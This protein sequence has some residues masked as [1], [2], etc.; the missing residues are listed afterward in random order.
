MYFTLWDQKHEEATKINYAPGALT[1]PSG[2]W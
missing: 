2:P 1:Y